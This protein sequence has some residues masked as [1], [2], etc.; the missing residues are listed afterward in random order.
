MRELK[1][2]GAR[3]ETLVRLPDF[4]ELDDRGR[5]LRQR[6][7]GAAT[8]LVACV[9][10]VVG[11][12]V[13]GRDPEGTVEPAPSP[14]GS[15]TYPGSTMQTLDPGTYVLEPPSLRPGL[16]GARFTVPSGWNSWVGP[17][18]FDGHAE[19]RDNEEALEHATWYVGVL[20]VHAEGVASGPCN[21]AQDF[22]VSTT[23]ALVGA[24][25]RIQG[26][27]I[28]REAEPVTKFGYP[29][30]HFRL[31]STAA[32]KGSCADGPGLFNARGHG[33]L[34][35]ST[36][37]IDVWVVDVKGTPVLVHQTWSAN[38][39]TAVRQELTEVVDSIEFFVPK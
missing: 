24:V 30:T 33:L 2:F 4:A 8:A 31:R 6:R 11:V 15:R 39:P 37:P 28:T 27:R 19:G 14:S 13:L 32:L 25:S 38:A 7:L 1:E 34:G 35:S 20:V 22:D 10:A 5:A 16:P 23:R 12:T 17:N 26:Y 9:L 21:T 29:A 3:A 18:R 36:D